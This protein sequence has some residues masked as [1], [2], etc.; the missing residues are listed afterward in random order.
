MGYLVCKTHSRSHALY[1]HLE[2]QFTQNVNIGVCNFVLKLQFQIIY[3][4]LLASPD[5]KLKL[6]KPTLL[7]PTF[8]KPT[9]VA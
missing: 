7:Y 4:A 1:L 8:A 9:Q 2:L 5:A 3:G 6:F